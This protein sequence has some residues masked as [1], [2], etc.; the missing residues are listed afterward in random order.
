MPRIKKKTAKKSIARKQKTISRKPSKPLK[1]TAKKAAGVNIKSLEGQVFGGIETLTKYWAKQAQTLEKR[2]SSLHSQIGKAAKKEQSAKT[3]EEAL[4]AKAKTKPSSALKKQIK[5]MQALFASSKQA[6]KTLS[7][8]RVTTQAELVDAQIAFQRAQELTS[9]VEKFEQQWAKNLSK[10]TK[11]IKAALPAPAQDATEA[12]KR[13]R[14]AKSA[15]AEVV[16]AEEGTKKRGRK[17]KATEDS[18]AEAGATPAKRRGRPKKELA[19]GVK[20]E[21]LLDEKLP[22][23]LEEEPIEEDEEYFAEEEYELDPEEDL[24]LDFEQDYPADISSD[25][26]SEEV[27]G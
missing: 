19:A 4:T 3:K 25:M 16:V 1:R 20:D 26:E 15:E 17:P 12:P 21:E 9:M 24:E 5:Q 8:E 10:L 14:K 27:M 23:L 6:T 13:G 18:T 7:Q 22:T 2:L 11:S